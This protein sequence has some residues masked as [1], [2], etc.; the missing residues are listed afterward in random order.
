[1]EAKIENIL[2][3]EKRLL[4]AIVAAYGERT[5]RLLNALSRAPK[6]Y[7]IRVN[8]LKAD[9]EKVVKALL[10][11]GV[12]CKASPIM[13][14]A[15]LVEVKGPFSLEREGK[16]VVA[17]KG[18]AESVMMGSNLYGP[19]VL[20]TDK[21]RLG[22][23]VSVED[24]KGHLVGK[25]IAVMS[26]KT[27]CAKRRGLAVEIKESIYRLPP[28]RE[29]SLYKQGLIR[30]Q[31]IPAMIASRVL[32]PK[33]GETV[34]DVCAAPGG[35]TLHIAQLM[36]DEGKI[37]AF[38]HS[39]RRLE[40]LRTDAERLGV[41]SVIPVCHD[42]RYIDR[43]FPTL[44]ADRVIVDPPCSAL[45]VRPKLYEDATYVKVRGCA[46]YQKQF[47]RVAS[48]IAKRGG[49]I[50]Y[51]TCTLTLE[52]NEEV[53]MYALEELGLDLEDQCIRVGEGGFL[54]GLGYAQR[55]SPDLLEMP[56]YFI[57]KFTKTEE[58]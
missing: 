57:A 4:E 26:P 14:E 28:F 53:V 44:R 7:A 24:P 32:E 43:D 25:G 16:T 6:D 56:G 21:Y 8:I 58:G 39:E 13:E 40:S 1:M 49:T 41:R 30:E 36:G 34:V 31:S 55:F 11:M 42:S 54:P 33:R 2:G 51:S 22:D 47:M 48:K 20:R 45:G 19:G 35:K 9:V 18:A 17:R 10:E 50:V 27:D 46:E 29:C 3:Y 5:N 52:E 23:V 38:D 37:Y 12:D 15:V